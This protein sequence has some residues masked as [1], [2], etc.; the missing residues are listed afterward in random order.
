MRPC[1]APIVFSLLLGIALHAQAPVPGPVKRPLTVVRPQELQVD[2]RLSPF[3]YP[4]L[5]SMGRV[6]GNVRL[7]VA[8]GPEGEVLAARALDGKQLLRKPAEALIRNLRFKPVLVQGKA[9]PVVCDLSVP[10]SLKDAMANLAENPVTGYV[11]H[12]EM[13]GREGENTLEA[14]TVAREARAMLAG[15]DLVP[16]EQDQA[17]PLT[18]LDLTLQ[19]KATAADGEVIVANVA[20]RISLLADR[21]AEVNKEGSP[22]KVWYLQRIIGQRTND[23][24]LALLGM[25]LKHLR[26]ALLSAPDEGRSDPVQLAD[27]PISD[28]VEWTPAPSFKMKDFDFSQMKVKLQ[29]SPPNY[30]P[31]AKIAR[32]QGTVIVE[33]IV[34]QTGAPTSAM[35]VEGPEALQ[36][37]SIAYALQWRFLPALLDGVPQTARFRLTMPF[38]LH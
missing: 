29:P 22:T 17:D 13:V 9:A 3:S 6:Q 24:G 20:S 32:I 12:V 5:A 30:P 11:L 2:R 10:F 4:I 15:L 26:G 37:A 7:R 23:R 19:V 8:I 31:L 35:A 21:K 1:P 25:A 38:R 36:E 18:T 14:A 16:R 28:A 34:D 27:G 33:L